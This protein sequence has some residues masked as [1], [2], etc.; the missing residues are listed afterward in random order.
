[1][2]SSAQHGAIRYPGFDAVRLVAAF[3]VLFSHSYAVLGRLD[4]E[5][6]V[7]AMPGTFVVATAAVACFFIVSGYLVTRSFTERAID[8]RGVISFVTARVLRIFPAYIVCLVF[9]LFLGAAV[10][11]LSATDYWR[12]PQT[13]H[14]LWYN[15]TLRHYLDLPGVFATNPAGSGVNGSIWTI[16]VEVGMYAMTLVFGLLAC[17]HRAWRAALIGV[18]VVAWCLLLPRWFVFFPHEHATPI[19]AVICYMIGAFIFVARWSQ[20]R[21][22]A[23]SAFA[24]VAFAVLYAWQLSPLGVSRSFAYIA[25][26]SFALWVARVAWPPFSFA[27]RFG[28]LSYGVFL[29]GAPVQQTLVWL[30]PRIGLGALIVA[31]VILSTAIAWCSWHLVEK[32]ALRLKPVSA[33]LHNTTA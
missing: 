18:V 15:A 13:W 4:Q 12:S 8:P 32:R 5:P 28:D 14:Y 25:I 11:T 2:S 3:G 23:L 30:F 19:Y 21:V 6:F 20:R 22:L 16:P 9:T 1:M 33:S 29:Y 24:A 27:T 26:A 31:C 17:W 7:R 10:T